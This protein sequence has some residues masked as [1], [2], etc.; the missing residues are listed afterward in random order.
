VRDIKKE[1]LQGRLDARQYFSRKRS[2]VAQGMLTPGTLA[3]FS[4]NPAAQEQY[5]PAAQPL[6]MPAV[7]QTDSLPAVARM[8]QQQESLERATDAL[9]RSRIAALNQA[10]NNARQPLYQEEE[11]SAFTGSLPPINQTV[12]EEISPFTGTL[13]TIERK[14]PSRV[15]ESS[16]KPTSSLPDWQAKRNTLWAYVGDGSDQTQVNSQRQQKTHTSGSL[17]SYA[18]KENHSRTEKRR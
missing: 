17:W 14:A 15:A 11:N 7:P 16:V 18:G 4:P 12:N 8:N 1:L 5:M 10:N 9:Q 6:P 3:A 13:P 2:Q